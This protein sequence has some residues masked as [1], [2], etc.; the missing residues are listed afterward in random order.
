MH[1]RHSWADKFRSFLRHM[2]VE[3]Q[4]YIRSHGHVQFISLSPLTQTAFAAI[5][6]VFLSWIAFASVNVVFKEQII[7]AKDR[8]YI[9]MQ[10]GYEERLAQ[11]Q[12][13]YD[14]LNGQLVIT[15]ERFLATTRQLEEKHK[16]L[17]ALMSQRQ[18]ASS[19]LDTMR[20]RYAATLSGQNETA[21]EGNTV[22]MRVDGASEGPDIVH[23]TARPERAEDLEP[24]VIDI[25]EGIDFAGL[26]GSGEDDNAV[27]SLIDTRLAQIDTAQQSLINNVEEVTDRR[28]RELKSIISMTKVV[29]PEEMLERTAGDGGEAQG[30]P[31]IDLA[32]TDALAGGGDESGFAKQLFRVS[33]NLKKM[34]DL[35]ESIARMP[36]ASPLVSYRKTSSFGSRRDPFNGRMAFHSGEDMAAYYGAPIYAPASGKV[37][38]AGWKGGYGRVIE[39]D[40]GNGFRTRYGHLGKISVKAGQEI[41]F[42][43]VLG[44]VGSSGRSS[45]PHLHYEVWFDGIVRNPSKFIEAGHYVF[46][47]QG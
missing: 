5:A 4:I 21:S 26:A 8:R 41:A 2:Y 45:G 10:G 17:A 20:R 13:A 18:T 43:E 33:Q 39:I 11:L 22:L 28:V 3:R 24:F 44:K 14:E 23:T 30:G 6:F 15:E 25:G 9:K 1:Q 36:L 7:A 34:A 29:D 32:D 16:Q 12:S 46:A 37:T 38:Y 27:V 40:H 35:E 42:R 19:Q 31:F 47:K